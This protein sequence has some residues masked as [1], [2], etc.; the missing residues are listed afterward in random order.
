MDS[1]YK[2]ETKHNTNTFCQATKKTATSIKHTNLPDLDFSERELSVPT[3]LL[4]LYR[5]PSLSVRCDSIF[6]AKCP[7]E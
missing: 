7:K 4:D 5:V 2:S 1:L 3:F 6:L